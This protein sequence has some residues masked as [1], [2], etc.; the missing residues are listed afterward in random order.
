MNV[1]CKQIAS[2]R[3]MPGVVEQ[4]WHLEFQITWSYISLSSLTS[5]M[6]IDKTHNLYGPWSPP[7]NGREIIS[8]CTRFK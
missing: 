2:Q 1:L 5:H 7:N 3:S 6:T 4:T 8:N